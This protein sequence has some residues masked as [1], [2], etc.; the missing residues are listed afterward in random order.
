M[1][2]LLRLPFLT[3][4]GA[5]ERF[6]AGAPAH[7]PLV[8]SQMANLPSQLGW[9]IKIEAPILSTGEIDAHRAIGLNLY[10]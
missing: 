10:G 2:T 3:D 4:L 9:R 6:S 1:L 5:G 8:L 7:M